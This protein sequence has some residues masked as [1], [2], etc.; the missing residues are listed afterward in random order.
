MVMVT[1]GGCFFPAD[2]LRPQA[3]YELQCPADQLQITELS[4]DCG[5]KAGNDYACT[6]GVR[7]CGKQA[8]YVHVPR[9]DTWLMNSATK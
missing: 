4:G 8:T 5:K 7:G 2:T 9:T 1:V 6:L 3:A